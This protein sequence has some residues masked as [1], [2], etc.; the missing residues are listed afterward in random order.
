MSKRN[1]M[2]WPQVWAEIPGTLTAWR[3]SQTF[4]QPIVIGTLGS[5]P[6]SASVL[7][8]AGDGGGRSHIFTDRG[9]VRVTREDRASALIGG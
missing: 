5:E 2:H 3:L 8:F 7:C 9:R 1:G 4:G 6:F